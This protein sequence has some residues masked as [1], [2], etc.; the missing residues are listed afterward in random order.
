LKESWQASTLAPFRSR[1]F[2]KIWS[3]SLVSNFGSLSQ[4]VGASWLMTSLAPSADYVALVQASTSLPIMLLALPSGA[5]AD[6]WDRRTIMIIAQAMMLTVSIALAV[7]AY[8][9]HLTPWS[10]LTFTF[11]IGCGT[12]L[13]GP[14]WQSSVGEQVPRE[15]IP[16]AVS[17]NTMSYNLARTAGPAVGGVIVAVAGASTAFVVNALTYVGLLTML[18][19]WKRPKP[20]Q[21]LPPETMFRAMG[22]GLR[23]SRL[24]PAIR[25][26]L[27]RG[28]VLGVAGGAIWAL[29]PLIAKD[30]LK[31]GPT[32]Y[33]VLFG[34]FGVGAVCGALMSAGARQK[35]E[36][37][38]LVRLATLGFAIT[39]GVSAFSPWLILTLAAFVI[40]GASWVLMLSTFNITVQLSSPRWVVGRSLA[41]YQMLVFGG[42]AIGSWM[43]GEIAESHGLVVALAASSVILALSTLL[44]FYAR[45]PQTDKLN[46][47]AARGA[48][49]V[50]PKV[51]LGPES[52]RVITT[53]TYQV[54]PENHAAFA[55]AMQEVRRI[56]RRDGARRWML[57]QDM[58]EPE[59]WV[60]RFHSPSWVEHVR[61]YH[62]F[63]VSD[64]EIE[65]RAL[66]FHRGPE[67][68]KFR[69][70]LER[71]AGEFPA[72]QT[73]A[74]KLG[75]Q[76]VVSDPNLPGSA[77][78]T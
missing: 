63:T 28:F 21:H 75:D 37:E 36:N 72:T 10:L 38:K 19:S 11:L 29:M 40:G 55:R 57:M 32:T 69:H 42:L 71:S 31:G 22:T 39:A 53:V 67:P 65:R 77:G 13:Y 50:T 1:T 74:Q 62:R 7:M 70:L 2:L 18:A 23:Y 68:P 12:A 8:V 14:A 20:E 48:F 5:I 78:S 24:S 15:H 30:L 51:E 76:A 73:E 44:G 26:V 35:L 46:L 16:A 58:T 56:R 47:A 49:T 64:Q 61:R 3:A 66:A 59:V 34:F 52:G 45:L 41:I 17:L 25:A 4:A 33:G 54:A 6:I 9:G 60:E 27:L 43:W